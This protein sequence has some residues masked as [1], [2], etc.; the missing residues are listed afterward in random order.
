MLR[1]CGGVQ[2]L[3]V[4]RWYAGVQPADQEKVGNE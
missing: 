2:E 4:C 1:A 3:P